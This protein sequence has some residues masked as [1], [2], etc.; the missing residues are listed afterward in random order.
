M[1][2]YNEFEVDPALSTCPPGDQAWGDEGF[3]A[4]NPKLT[5]KVT[6]AVPWGDPYCEFVYEFKEE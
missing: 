1:E 2:R 3:K 5:Y 4:V 6:K